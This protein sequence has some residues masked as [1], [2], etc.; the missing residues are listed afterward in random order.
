MTRLLILTALLLAPLLA[1]ATQ[2]IWYEKGGDYYDPINPWHRKS[3]YVDLP[4]PPIGE[5]YRAELY[6]ANGQLALE[7]ES[8]TPEFDRDKLIGTV[9]EYHPNG[10]I[11]SEITYV[12]RNE[13]CNCGSDQIVRHGTFKEYHPNGQLHR[14]ENY[15]AGTQADGE[16]TR[17]DEE[18]R[19]TF[20]YGV[21]GV[22]YHGAYAKY[23]AGQLIIETHYV[24]GRRHGPYREFDLQG[25]PLKVATLVDGEYHGLVETYR[26]GI[27]VEQENY[28]DGQKTGPQKRFY[29]DGTLSRSY[30]ASQFRGKPEGEDLH[31]RKDGTLSRKQVTTLDAKGNVAEVIEQRFDEQGQLKELEHKAGEWQLTETYDSAG[32]LIHRR[33]QDKNGLQGLFLADEWSGLVRAH[34]L[35]GKEHGAYFKE[36]RD[37]TVEK[38]QYQQGRK[39]GLWVTTAKDG[40]KE[41]AHY[42][43]GQKHGTLQRYSAGGALTELV[44]YHNGEKHGP[45]DFIGPNGHRII[46]NFYHGEPDGD[47]RMTTVD[48]GVVQQGQFVKGQ[49]EGVHYHFSELGQLREKRSYLG[50]QPHGEWVK[51]EL[52]GR[53][54]V[55][56]TYEQGELLSEREITL[57]ELPAPGLY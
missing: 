55:V 26:D 19:V 2:R 7:G 13:V 21:K 16:Y 8:L 30:N 46:G 52:D 36:N 48:G 57:S 4:L 29:P 14:M 23:E 38:G 42:A 9:V 32:N 50:G 1:E 37:G 44:T 34:Y 54:R 20:R 49:P 12:T 10:Q 51:T 18:G 15:V 43:N 27:L 5:R 11:A 47:Y 3:T 40:T 35:N 53:I 31:Y 45:A 6:H 33:E 22:R 41:E 17:Y 56:K 28:Q 24:N 39:D 25:R